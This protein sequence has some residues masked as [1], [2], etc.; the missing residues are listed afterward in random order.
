MAV[1]S[2]MPVSRVPTDLRFEAE[3]F[4]P[5]YIELEEQLSALSC[6]S[7]DSLSL[8]I[9]SGP[10][11]S[12][13]MKSS[14]V[15][16]G[17]IVLRPFNI[18]EA[19]FEE[20]NL[21]YI[22]E[23]DVEAQGLKLYQPGDVGFARVGDIRC[24]IIPD[25]DRPITISPNIIVAH[26]DE[27]RLDPY[28]LAV[29]MNTRFGFLQLERGVKIVAQPT[30][31]VETVKSILVPKVTLVKQ[32]II[33]ELLKISIQKRRLSRA[34][35]KEA[36]SSLL[37]ELGL[38]TINLSHQTSYTA[39]FGEV[40]NANRFDAE[41]FQPKYLRILNAIHGSN[42]NKPLGTLV[43]PIRNGFDFREFTKDGTP[44]I[45]VGDIRDG[46]I[47]LDNA[48]KIPIT[49]SDIRKN[50]DLKAGD[51]LFTRKGS[52]GN[53]AVVRKGQ[54]HVVISSEI[55]LLRLIPDVMLLPDYLALFLNSVLG[56]QQIE[57][58]VHGV[59]YYSITQLDLAQVEIMIPAL[60][61]QEKLS[62][63]VQKS[64]NVEIEAKQLL[65]KAIGEVEKMILGE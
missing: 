44:Y 36:Q 17:V 43:E 27:K 54:D 11:G 7:L 19:T 13:L 18:K 29:F 15:E 60:N 34:L 52:F 45:R 3:Y 14:Y 39:Y 4:Q 63:L 28:F 5:R 16:D 48:E 61:V 33:G 37:H 46:R 59:A 20:S 64:L 47:E 49:Q 57:R 38:N 53:V 62:K 8:N 9:N 21:V 42:L 30:I 58:K 12:N 41:Y 32:K 6:D 50:I 65:V 35:Y 26:I 55:M 22:L 51:V 56:Y 24:G 25:Y 23:E 40:K 2:I 31:T 10:F 1:W